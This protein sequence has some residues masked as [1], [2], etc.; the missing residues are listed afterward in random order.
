MRLGSI[1]VILWLVVGAFAAHQRNYYTKP[2][3]GCNRVA[4]ITVTI[5]AGPLNYLGMNPKIDCQ[6]PQP[7]K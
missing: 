3:D 6:T 2:I 5:L 7:S 4:T 1:L